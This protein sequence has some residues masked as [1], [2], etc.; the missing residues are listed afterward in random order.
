MYSRYNPVAEEQFFPAAEALQSYG[1]K[2]EDVQMQPQAYEKGF[3][4]G[5]LDALKSENGKIDYS[6]I[7]I[8]LITILL[9]LSESENDSEIIIIAAALLIFG[10]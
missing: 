4:G 9:F 10:Y 2:A 7:I 5:I 1:P 3:L 8:L 6:S